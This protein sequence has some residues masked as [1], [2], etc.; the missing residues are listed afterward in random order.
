MTMPTHTPIPNIINGAETPSHSKQSLPVFNPANA[1]TIAHVPCSL[2]SDLD[3]AVTSATTAQKRWAETPV[4]D[5]IQILYRLKHLIHENET[6]LAAI[7]SQENGKTLSE[8]KGSLLRGIECIEFACGL[9]QLLSGG[10][11]EVGTGI[12]CKLYR[13]PLG[14]VAGITPFN[15]P[16][17]VPLW[18]IPIAIGCG[19]AFILKPS[20][21]TPLSANAIG[22]LFKE[23][24]LPD[25]IFSVIHGDRQLAEAICD[26]PQI[27]AIGFVGSSTS[28]QAIYHR[29]TRNN[30][31]IRALGGA[32]NHLIIV[33][34]A[35]PELAA[36]N[37]VAS[38]TGCAGQRCMAASVLIAVGDVDTV[39]SKIQKEMA[40]ITPGADMGPVISE[41]ALDRITRYID[42]AEQSGAT[43]LLDGRK[44]LS[45]GNP[46]GWYI[47]PTI[48][49]GVSPDHES[50][51]DEIFGPVLTILRCNTL[52]EAITI[53]AQSPYGNAA[54]IYTTSGQIAQH[55]AEKA[56]SGMIGIN[57]GVPVPREPFPFGGWHQS[58][59]GEGDITGHGAIDFWTKSK[60]IT[61]KWGVPRDTNWMS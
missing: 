29:A 38:V 25:G 50:A 4:K 13:Y 1:E 39:I 61:T 56:T 28:A 60:K 36:T 44:T 30:K 10:V 6:R 54:A 17:M 12:E 18:M 37:I 11:L 9:P 24:G 31:R 3:A 5:R 21:Q 42:R 53:E 58:Y 52:E 2:K 14:V 8:A 19:N 15:F 7:I 26:H 40:K 32:K 49:D 33:P 59:F 51:C 20:E 55:V 16:I 34:D 35:D 47:G 41:N 43:L 22:R 45:S 27:Q 23:S 57:I 48:I 46:N